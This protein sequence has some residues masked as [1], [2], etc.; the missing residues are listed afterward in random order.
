MHKVCSVDIGNRKKIYKDLE[1]FVRRLRNMPQVSRAYIYGSFAK[2]DIHEGSD[3]DLI[4]VGSFR[5]RIFERIN[6]ITSLT[7]LPVEPLVYTEEEFEKKQKLGNA[8]ILNVL[9]DAKRVI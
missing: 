8:F 2:G 1:S 7:D 4:V 3:I 5:G 6:S 9:R